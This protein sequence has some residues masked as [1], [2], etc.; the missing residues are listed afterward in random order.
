[1]FYHVINSRLYRPQHRF[2]VE[3]RGCGLI[4]YSKVL[5]TC[6]GKSWLTWT[7]CFKPVGFR[8]TMTEDG[9]GPPSQNTFKGEIQTTM[10]PPATCPSIFKQTSVQAF[11]KQTTE[12]MPEKQNW[13]WNE[14]FGLCGESESLFFCM[15]IL[16][17]T[18]YNWL[19]K[20]RRGQQSLLILWLMNIDRSDDDN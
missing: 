15:L 14:V 7:T 1:M 16:L 13:G 6:P 19:R 18:K 9:L 2:V 4:G 11:V 5:G 20:Q 12:K 3:V 17:Q 8:L 10:T